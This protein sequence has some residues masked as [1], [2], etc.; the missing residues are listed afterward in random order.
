MDL[1]VTSAI[2]DGENLINGASPSL[3][4]RELRPILSILG[5]SLPSRPVVDLLLE[6]YFDSVHWFSLVIYEPLF[7]KEYESVADGLASVPQ[8][9]F[10]TL[11]TVVL[12]IA[13]WYRSQKHA[14]GG[15]EDWGAWSSGL[16]RHTESQLFELMD[17]PSL[18]SVQVCILLGSYGV[19][20]GKP[21][22]SFALLGAAIKMAQALRLHREPSGGGFDM[23]E[24]RKR[25]WW[26]IYTWDR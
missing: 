2:P 15:N 6:E 3:A 8:K 12:S 14:V 5:Y 17:R 10:L 9:A 13:A 26:T 25:I 21:N 20:H 7:R 1:R 16:M 23:R 19:Y 11:L 24:E 18:T 4:A 22:S